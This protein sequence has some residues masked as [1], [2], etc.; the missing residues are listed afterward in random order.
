MSTI[1]KVGSNVVV[2]SNR[3]TQPAVFANW[4]DCQVSAGGTAVGSPVYLT[5][6]KSEG[7]TFSSTVTDRDGVLTA[8]NGVDV[9]AFTAPQI[10]TLITNSVLTDDK[11]SGT[12]EVISDTT[13]HEGQYTAIQFIEDTVLDTAGTE[14]VDGSGT[15]IDISGYTGLTFTAGDKIY[16][17]FTSIQLD[18]GGVI[19]YSNL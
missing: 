8:V 7:F 2:Q 15:P 11:F 19:A 9:T 12:P 5:F 1:T 6:G 13:A 18:S 14:Q 16:G 10:V 17:T 3:G 4:E